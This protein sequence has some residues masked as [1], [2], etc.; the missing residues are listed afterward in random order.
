MFL[1]CNWKHQHSASI[2]VQIM[3][4]LYVLFLLTIH[5]DIIFSSNVYLK[6]PLLNKS[7]TSCLGSMPFSQNIIYTLSLR[8]LSHEDH[9]LYLEGYMTFRR[10]NFTEW[11]DVFLEVLY[12]R[13]TSYY[14][15]VH[16]PMIRVAPDRYLAPMNLSADI[17]FPSC[18]TIYSEIVSHSRFPPVC[19]LF[20][21]LVTATKSLAYMQ[22]QV[23]IVFH[24]FIFTVWLSHLTIG[25]IGYISWKKHSALCFESSF[26][27]LIFIWSIK[28][29]YI[30]W[31]MIEKSA[32]T[33]V[34]LL[35]LLF[36]ILSYVF[37]ACL[38]LWW[39]FIIFT[40]PFLHG[41]DSAEDFFSAGLVLIHP[42]AC[43]SSRKLFVSLSIQKDNCV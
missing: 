11:G 29:L 31:G 12:S 21:G 7:T 18:W 10:R 4:F 2:Y 37:L 30:V 25:Y 20:W 13:H 42:F 33:P 3:W 32:L 41:K 15:S 34:V 22:T 38:I 8:R 35:L 19:C 6:W 14:F 43:C 27:L 9:Q 5:S 16:Y 24:S 23:Y 1:S 36:L 26:L 40:F 28:T 39:Y 17:P